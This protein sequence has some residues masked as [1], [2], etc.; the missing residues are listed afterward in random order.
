MILTLI[1]LGVTICFLIF[2]VL[3]LEVKTSYYEQTFKNNKDKFSTER[4]S[5]I[6]KVMNLKNPFKEL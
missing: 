6:E 2:R 3:L 4:Y 1:I 5:H